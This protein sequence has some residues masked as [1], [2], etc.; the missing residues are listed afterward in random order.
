MSEPINTLPLLELPRRWELLSQRANA[1]GM[2]PESFVERVDDAAKR[3]DYLLTRVRTGGGGIFEIFLGL[4]GSGK[5]TFLRTLPRFFTSIRV[6]PFQRDQALIELPT[7]IENT[8]VPHDEK[9]RIILIERRDNPTPEELTSSPRVFANLLETFRDS[10]GAVLVIWPI[11]NTASARELAVNAW[12]TGRDSVCDSTSKGVFQFVGPPKERFYYIADTTSRNLTGDGLDAFGVTPETISPLLSGCETIADFFNA[13]DRKA[14]ETRIAAWSVLKERVRARIW[15]VLPGDDVSAI[16]GTVS[17][18]TQGTRS[19]VD[20]DMIAEFIDRPDNDALYIADWRQ[21]R[22]S[23]AHLLRILD[24][25]VFGLPPNVALAAIRAFGEAPLKGL[26]R[27]QTMN[28]SQAKDTM[29]SSRLYKAILAEAGIPSP[30]F[31]AGR[32]VSP[33][34][35]NEY[36]RIQAVASHNDKPLNKAL[37]LLIKSCLCDDIP[38]TEVITEQR[39]LPGSELQPDVQIR[40]SESDF[41]CL[42]PT[43]RSTD[44]GIPGEISG[45][46]NTLTEAH[47]KKYVLEK[48]TQYVRDFGL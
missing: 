42:E 16:N 44:V 30:P 22:S 21:R 35:S 46:Q 26:L 5:T 33:E 39:K 28:L 19:R 29:R 34:T 10:R 23:L 14:D 48:A 9:R 11:T 47:I 4:S 36:R 25:R 24:V 15:V 13:V 45:G 3:I 41:I 32:N 12:D 1:I 20:I 2:N 38:S 31:V 17:A 8:F 43:W 40:L 27:Q 6:C 37:G 7:F 18:L